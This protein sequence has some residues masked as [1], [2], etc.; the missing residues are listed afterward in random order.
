MNLTK[1][2][3]NNSRI[4]IIALIIIAAMGVKNYFDLSQDSMPPY[5]IR[6]ATVITQFP[7]ASPLRVEEL[8]TDPLE[9]S[10]REMVEVKSIESESRSGLSVITIELENEISNE[11]LRD[12]W[13]EL[14]QKMDDI[15]PLL[16][17]GTFGPMVKDKDIGTVFGVILG[18]TSDGVEQNIVE[19]HARDIRDELL[20]LPDVEKVKYGGIQEERVYI[21]MDD[22]QLSRYGLTAKQLKNI[23]ASTNILYSGGELVLGKRRILIEPTGNFETIDDVKNTLIPVSNGASLLLGDIANVYSDY[24]APREKIVKVNG[25]QAIALYISLRDGANIVNLGDDVSQLIQKINTELPIGIELVR[26]A[27]QDQI[28]SKQVNDFLVSLIQSIVIVLTVMLLFLGFRTG[29]LVAAL[30]PMV[31][32]FSFFFMYV[33]DIGLNKVSLAALIIS[34]GLLVDNGIVMAESILTRTG[35]GQSVRD[36]S[37]A[38]CKLLMIPLLIS[39][40]TTS[41]AFLSFALAQ[42]PMGEMASPLFYVVTIAL[43]SSWFL[44]FTFVPLLALAI[45]KVKQKSHHQKQSRLDRGMEK[46][47]LWY[48][49]VLVKALKNPLLVTGVVLSLFVISL[50][51]LPFLPFKLVPDSDRNLVT[52]DIKLP[53]GTKIELTEK[54]VAVVEEYIKDS[55]LVTNAGNERG[56]LDFSSY[57]GEGPEA[58]DLGFMKDEPNSNY[59]H[60]LLNTTGDTDNEYIIEKLDQF[61]Y[62]NLPEADIRVNRLSGAGAAGTPVEIYISGKDMEGLAKIAEQLKQQMYTVKGVKNVTDDWGPKIKKLIVQIDETKAKR[63][64]LTNA[65]IATALSTGLSGFSVGS[66]REGTKSIP[67][68]LKEPTTELEHSIEYVNSLNVYSPQTN[69]NVTLGQ[70]ADVVLDWQFAKVN[71]RELNRT[72]TVGGYLKPGYTAKDIFTD[73]TPWLEEQ[74]KIWDGKYSYSFGG[75]DEDTNENLGAIFQWLPISFGLII[76]LLVLQF[77]SIRKAGIIIATIP[78]GMIGVVIGWYIGQ[79]FV[80]FFG[81]LGVIALAG[82]LINDSIV[83]L[84]RIDVEKEEG[85]DITWQDAIMRAANHKFR[86]VLLTTLTTSLGMIPLLISGGLLWEPLALAIIFGLFFATV[87]ILLLVPV[88]YRLLFRVSFKDY[89][90]DAST[91]HH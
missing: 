22:Q 37:I 4:Y 40:L 41:S 21:E 6:M 72:I 58:Y 91:L 9:E 14:R 75:E 17:Q 86:P 34:L 59:A 19:E 71:R 33:L 56:V 46:L 28:V 52:V 49:K 44:V 31:V 62:T 51:A 70:I 66:F 10:I 77:N 18:V 57:I 23:I 13:D 74:N 29:S 76:F 26:V 89:E 55:L 24:V 12:V 90:F 8:V 73:L 78:L 39:S 80:S 79:S 25:E 32:L 47:N 27:S 5:T 2:T 54:T 85:P 45:V 43:L 60:M 87:L 48:N 69:L 63:V 84:D 42:T 64:G 68:I 65:D 81:I 38:A 15:K 67:I 1:N 35:S 61:C 3:L 88:L 82:I 7:G 20:Q 36:A 16:P 83:L 50:I 30:I 11:N 53:T